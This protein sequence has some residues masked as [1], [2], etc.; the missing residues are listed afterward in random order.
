MADLSSPIYSEKD[1]KPTLVSCGRLPDGQLSHH[2]LS[3]KGDSSADIEIVQNTEGATSAKKAFLLL[4]KAFIGTG[5]LFL[6]KAF[7]NGGLVVAIAVLFVVAVI[8][9][10][11]MLLLV[12][13]R[14]QVPGDF[15]AI[16]EKIYGRPMKIV[17]MISITISQIGFCCAYFIFV[18]QNLNDLTR[19]LSNCRMDIPVVYFIFLQLV[20]YM[21]FSLVRKIKAFSH[22]ALLADV[23][24]LFGIAY[25]LYRDVDKLA[26]I[27]VGKIQYFNTKDYPLFIGT[28]LFS[29]EGIGLVL[30][31]VNSMKEPKRFPVVLSSVIVAV[32]VIFVTVGA[33]SYS[34]FGD[35][36][37]TIVLLNMP[38]GHP[39]TITVQ[40]LYVA[41]ILLTL[42]LM[43]FPAIDIFEEGIFGT[44]SGGTSNMVK[45]QKNLFRILLCLALAVVAWG[46]ASNLD[47]FV[48]LIGGFGC[49]PL[50]F[51]YPA[52]FHYKAI[53][54]KRLYK[55]GNLL[56]I[57]FG[58]V[59]MIFV[60]YISIRSW[61]AAE[62]TN[63]CLPRS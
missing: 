33:M 11:A 3:K 25:I 19:S 60:T 41:A 31:I 26:T 24:I 30:P 43:L 4:I 5:V 12:K 14:L 22:A 15:G 40:F 17:V 29:Y 7:S 49:I 20:V 61:A 59:V 46:G 54:T 35:K 23:F 39:M 2:Q 57:G 27:G 62:V 42:P 38:A 6:P 32:T 28:A 51:I 47:N 53:A 10:V 63:N 50:L 55:V 21:P 36:T 56:L 48:S 44:K 45:W 34:A 8:T 13:V 1:E 58:F 37:E 16:G 9:S 18:A 52:M